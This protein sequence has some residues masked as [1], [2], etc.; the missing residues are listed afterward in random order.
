MARPTAGGSA[1]VGAV[2]YRPPTAHH[3]HANLHLGAANVLGLQAQ[4]VA[5]DHDAIHMT[6][7]VLAVVGWASVGLH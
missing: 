1:V 5:V 7:N 2:E 4:R 6:I 3:L